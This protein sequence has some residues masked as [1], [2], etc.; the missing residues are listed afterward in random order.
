MKKLFGWMQSKRQARVEVPAAE[1]KEP[2]A[3]VEVSPLPEPVEK[4]K[5]DAGEAVVMGWGTE[6]GEVAEVGAKARTQFHEPPVG[7]RGFPDFAAFCA[8]YGAGCGQCQFFH[9]GRGP[10]CKVWAKAWPDFQKKEKPAKYD[11]PVLPREYGSQIDRKQLKADVAKVRA[12]LRRPPLEYP[13]GPDWFAFCDG[14]PAGCDGCRY[15][16]STT[17]CWCQLWETYF[18]GVVK[19][20]GW[21][22]EGQG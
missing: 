17:A 18:P 6:H 7:R 5:A 1:K 14:Y 10:F 15:Y 22:G 3:K 9:Q 13:D 16:R 11:F 8:G 20:Y 4:Q 19:W 12:R 21:K 2:P